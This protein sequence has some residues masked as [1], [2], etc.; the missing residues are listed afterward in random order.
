MATI[1]PFEGAGE[2]ELK[3]VPDSWG[4]FSVLGWPSAALV[5]A[6]PSKASPL[7]KSG[8]VLGNTIHLTNLKL[9]VGS[10]L[11][12]SMIE[13]YGPLPC[14]PYGPGSGYFKHEEDGA[15]PKMAKR[16]EALLRNVTGHTPEAHVVLPD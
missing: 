14:N 16:L 8:N 9:L 12:C 6:S 2:H 13:C 1:R 15:G 7:I 10:G 4:L 11:M 5:G 3:G